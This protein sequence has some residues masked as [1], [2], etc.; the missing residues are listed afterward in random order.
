VDTVSAVPHTSPAGEPERCENCG[1]GGSFERAFAVRADVQR[2]RRCGGWAFSGHVAAPADELYGEEY[3]NG[4]EYAAYDAA[5]ASHERNFRRKLR[6]LRRHGAPGPADTRLLELGCATGEF[7]AEA[8]RAGVE[9]ALGLEVSAYCRDVARRRGHEVLSPS[10]AAAGRAVTA[11]RPNLVVAWDVWEHLRAPASTL[12][13]LLSAADRRVTVALTTVDAGSAVARIRRTSWR[14]FHPPTHLYY[15][16]RRSLRLYFERAGFEVVHH[17]SF[18]YYRPLAEYLRVLGVHASP[19]PPAW[20]T[21]PVF[22][23]L[24]DIQLVIARRTA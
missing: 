19:S 11:L 12:D 7:L 15:P 22:L 5:R 24:F 17:G 20:L 10:D 6:L 3:F 21:T 16:T 9:R 18:G 8:K 2:C 14:Q 23:D 13:A 4:G 1:G